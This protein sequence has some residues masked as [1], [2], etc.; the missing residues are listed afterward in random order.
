MRK[1]NLSSLDLNLLVAFDALALERNVTRAATRI[2]LSQSALSKAL[3]R[4]RDVFEDPL[5]V[6]R[7]RS[8]EPTPRALGL[9]AP[10]RSALADILSHPGAERL[11]PGRGHRNSQDRGR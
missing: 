6:R 7:D 1:R 4:L 9:V 11:R 8:M 3:N 2:G 10:I 5:F